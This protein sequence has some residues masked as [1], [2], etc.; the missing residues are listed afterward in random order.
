MEIVD[1]LE[2][3]LLF[4]SPIIIVLLLLFRRLKDENSI[5]SCRFVRRTQTAQCNTIK[6]NRTHRWDHL[7]LSLPVV[8]LIALMELQSEKIHSIRN[9]KQMCVCPLPE[10]NSISSHFRIHFC[11]QHGTLWP[12]VGIH[13]SWWFWLRWSVTHK[14]TL[15]CN[16]VHGFWAP[17]N[18][19]VGAHWTSLP[20]TCWKWV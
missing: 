3:S 7:S 12:I 13:F 17:H 16:I 20:L 10:L 8:F 1:L 14:Y 15:E 6:L 11:S 4:Q 9:W 18:N 19:N 5:Q 2:N